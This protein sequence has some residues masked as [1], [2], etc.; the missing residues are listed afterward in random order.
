MRDISALVAY[1][2]SSTK[3]ASLHIYNGTHLLLNSFANTVGNDKDTQS[4]NPTAYPE[5]RGQIINNLLQCHRLVAEV[6]N[7]QLKDNIE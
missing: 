6:A 2:L 1:S 3:M 7:T 5:P 4:G